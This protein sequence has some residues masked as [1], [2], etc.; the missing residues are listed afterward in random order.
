ML[1]MIKKANKQKLYHL[2]SLSIVKTK[3]KSMKIE[4]LV[5]KILDWKNDGEASGEI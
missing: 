5:V 3:V 4:L 1:L 2:N